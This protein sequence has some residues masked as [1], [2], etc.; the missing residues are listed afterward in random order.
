M[1]SPLCLSRQSTLSVLFPA[2][3]APLGGLSS[4]APFP[5]PALVRL[6]FWVASGSPPVSRSPPGKETSWGG[7]QLVI[8]VERDLAAREGE[9]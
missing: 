9:I 5:S 6:L 2:R 4:L 7:S 8:G 1:C 3:S